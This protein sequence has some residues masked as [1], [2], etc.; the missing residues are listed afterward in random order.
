M[1]P[2]VG[3]RPMVG[4]AVLALVLA[5]AS[6]ALLAGVSGA[7]T[8]ASA[9]AVAGTLAFLG[10]FVVAMLRRRGAVFG[11]ADTVTLV[12]AA[13]AAWCTGW[14]VLTVA[15]ALP[16]QSWWLLVVSVTALVLDGVD[17]AVARR[18]GSAGASGGRLDAETD[19]A[20][21][22]V[23]SVAAAHTVGWWVL[24][25]GLMRY[26]FAAGQGLRPRWR[27]DLPYR[28]SRRVVAATQGGILA[29]V[30]GPIVPLWL[31]VAACVL[32]LGLLLLSFARDVFWLER[33]SRAR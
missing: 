28:G 19:A 21:I 27:A 24:A 17:G 20:L 9:A 14:M 18:T 29:G 5:A 11:P 16:A 32:G 31:A 25:S 22:L 23:L 26:A 13:L 7:P 30:S 10:V 12:R 2:R 3:R 1:S 4:Q 8:G 33:G 6:C 15:G